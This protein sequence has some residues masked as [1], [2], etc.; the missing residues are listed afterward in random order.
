MTQPA[1]DTDNGNSLLMDVLELIPTDRSWTRAALETAP[2]AMRLG[3][4]GGR[5]VL[6]LG[7]SSVALDHAQDWLEGVLGQEPPAGRVVVVGV[8]DGGLV[9]RLLVEWPETPLVVWEQEGEVLRAWIAGA[10]E[11]VAGAVRDGRLELAVGTDVL[12][13]RPPGADDRV[14]LHP[15]LGPSYAH[16]MALWQGRPGPRAVVG[17]GKLIAGDLCTALVEEGWAPW[18][19]DVDRCGA[20][21]L[22]HAAAQLGAEAV[23]VIN[24]AHGLAEVCAE[25]GLALLEWEIDPAMDRPRRPSRPVPNAHVFTWR[26]ANVTQFEA[27]GFPSV[28]HLPLAAPDR[29][30]PLTLSEAERARF[31]AQVSFV[32]ESMAGRAAECLGTA[33][34]AL[35][36]WL[37]RRG[38]SPDQASRLL[39]EVMEIQRKDLDAWLIPGLLRQRFPG[40]DSGGQGARVDMLL[41]EV[42]AAERRLTRVAALAPLG[43]HAWGDPGWQRLASLGVTV[44]GRAGHFDTL[45]RIYNATRINV[46]IGRLYQRDI[47]TMRVFDV[48]RCGA[49]VLADHSEALVELLRPGVE[50]ET[51]RTVGELVDKARWYLAH[52]DKADAI[53]ARGR[54]AVVERHSVRQRVAQ[55]LALTGL[56][57]EPSPGA[58]PALP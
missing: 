50:V 36:R 42:A 28:H 15:V 32:G 39:A 56:A 19:L 57:P 51:W 17:S 6:R 13:L 31:G 35:A 7:A 5:R 23:V 29:R 8:G 14:V 12:Q 16:G 52:P 49:F 58:P 46:D 1:G 38:R 25:A 10:S 11:A 48:L 24:H 21:R 26:R 3:V 18:P 2:E 54:A 44:R 37:V 33:A 4:V 22:V 20:A 55:M 40:L 43:V 30:Q 53:A 45:T 34:Q 47:V 27:V 41:G 9:E